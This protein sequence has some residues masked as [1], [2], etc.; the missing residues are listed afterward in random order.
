ME[1][2]Q[3]W[4]ESHKVDLKFDLKNQS[5]YTRSSVS[6]GPEIFG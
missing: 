3:E 5:W 2:G 6:W 1:S 4:V